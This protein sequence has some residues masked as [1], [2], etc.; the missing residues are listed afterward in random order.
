MTDIAYRSFK[1]LLYIS[2]SYQ[3]SISDDKVNES[4]SHAA[5]YKWGIEEF[6]EEESE[7]EKRL[8]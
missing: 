2:G 7:L 4:H 6:D 8:G 5:F 3:Y 1:A